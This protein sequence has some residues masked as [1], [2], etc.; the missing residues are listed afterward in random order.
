MRSLALLILCAILVGCD[1]PTK[2]LRT[3]PPPGE[4]PVA[5]LP[6]SMHVRNWTDRAGSGSCVH[7]S[8]L[9]ILNWQGEYEA[10]NRWRKKY[11]GGE[12]AQ[13]ITNYYKANNMPF[14]CTLNGDPA[15][16]VWASQNRRGAIVW[17]KPYHCCAFVGISVIDGKEYAI[18]QDN[19]R[20][21]TF[22][23]TPLK[24]FIEK[25][26]GY[27]G[28]ACTLLLSP[29]QSPI[30]WPTSIPERYFEDKEI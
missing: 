17:W 5:N 4:V 3:I 1:Q 30:P 12:T 18:I 2:W 6:G 11:A 20:P 14:A 7:A 15:F 24:E 21:G 23:K 26:R 19:N 22:E 9:F 29:P 16:L 25:W 27:G 13:S 8:T 10:A 28:F